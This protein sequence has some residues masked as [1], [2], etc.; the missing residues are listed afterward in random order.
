MRLFAFLCA[1]LCTRWARVFARVACV[2]RLLGCSF[3][4]WRVCVSVLDYVLY[5]FVCLFCLFVWL[6]VCYCACV[7][8]FF[9]FA[10]VVVFC[11]WRFACLFV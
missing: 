3:A 11:L 5:V 2:C 8:V 1:C 6:Y 9:V 7:F 4:C 10:C